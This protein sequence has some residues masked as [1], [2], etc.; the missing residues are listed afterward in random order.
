MNELYR[1]KSG[2]WDP[3]AGKAISRIEREE[4]CGAET[5]WFEKGRKKVVV[6]LH[7]GSYCE[8]PV[9]Q[10]WQFCDRIAR[11]SDASVVVPL[12]RMAPEHTFETAFAY[13]TALWELL[14]KSVDAERIVLMGDSAGGG[15]ALAFAEYLKRETALP[16]PGRIVL[17][18]PWLDLGMDAEIPEKLARQDP[19]LVREMLRDAGK[20]WAGGT[21]THDYRLSPLY[22]EL[23]GLAPMTLYVGTHE[24]FL[25]DARRFRERCER[26]GAAA[27]VAEMLHKQ[28]LTLTPKAIR[29]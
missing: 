16:Q 10:H 20:N 19:T 1:N 23:K 28:V 26:E 7:G 13:L 5:V 9:L 12:Y 22:G 6:Y 25:P 2:Y 3:T 14:L 15:L 17:F 11:E 27:A 8:Q 18:S 21:D 29:L 4:L 24:I